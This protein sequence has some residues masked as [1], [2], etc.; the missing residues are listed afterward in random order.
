MKNILANVMM[1]GARVGVVKQ[2]VSSIEFQYDKKWLGSKIQTSPVMMPLS[3]DVY[4]FPELN[5]INAF[6]GLPGLLA[7]ALPDQFGN[8]IIAAHL[9]KRGLTFSDLTAVEK[10]LYMGDRSMGALEFEPILENQKNE[11]IED[12]KNKT[13]LNIHRISIDSIDFLKDSCTITIYYYEN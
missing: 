12:L 8:K 3:S 13:G 10:L 7:D 6:Q 5:K 1:W 11:L 4:Q 9:A 2:G